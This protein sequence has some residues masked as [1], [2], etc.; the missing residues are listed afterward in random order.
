MNARAVIRM[1][2]YVLIVLGLAMAGCAWVSLHYDDPLSAVRGLAG[3][4]VLCLAFGLVAWLGSRGGGDLSRRD[5]FGIVTFGWLAAGIFGALPFLLSGVIPSPV[6]AVFETVSGFTTT[7]ATVLDHPEAV[8]RGIL[9]WRALTH[10]FG[11]M[12]VLVL[13]VAILPLLGTSGMQVFQAE[14]AGPTKDRLTP[15]ITTTAKYLWGMYILLCALE[16]FLLRMGGMSWF[17]AVCH[18]FATVATGG[19]STRA[20][21]I[22]YYHSPYIEIVILVFMFLSGANF[23]LHF[24]FLTGTFGAHRRDPEFRFYFLVWLLAGLFV[25]IQIFGRPEVQGWGTAARLGFFQVTSML[26]STGFATADFDL[27]PMASRLLLVLLM[28]FGGCAGSTSGGIKQIRVFIV[29]KSILR[30]IRLAVLS[31]S[32]VCVKIAKQPIDTAV[33]SS[34][35]GFTLLY[36]GIF[37]VS[38]LIMALYTPDLE[39]AVTSVC[40]TM[41]GV[42]PGLSKVGPMTTFSSI[43]GAGKII[44]TLCMLLGRLELITIVV[45]FLPRFWRR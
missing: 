2:S 39:T 43:P 34:V 5:G 11:G 16:T 8:P 32:V 18:S 4:S 33:V 35:L 9:F 21:S 40:T 24:R 30:E 27:W 15:R 19:F 42:G 28:F 20:E 37:A 17:D 38:S 12:G 31:H 6:D 13:V 41:G 45:L 25:T 3:S 23:A 36:L 26:T 29:L 1:V 7:G 44:L 14:M 10:F 22:A